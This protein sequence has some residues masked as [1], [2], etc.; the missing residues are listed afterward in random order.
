MLEIVNTAIPVFLV[1]TFLVLVAGLVNLFRSG[2]T[3]RNMSQI[4]MR[5]RV[6]LQFI[7]VCLIALAAFLTQR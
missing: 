2:G 3:N 7:V 5:W 4:L 6:L 1:L